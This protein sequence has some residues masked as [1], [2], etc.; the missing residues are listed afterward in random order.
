MLGDDEEERESEMDN[1]QP[2]IQYYVVKSSANPH[3]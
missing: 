2:E 3:H 1:H